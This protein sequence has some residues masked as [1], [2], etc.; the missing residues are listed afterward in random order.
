[1]VFAALFAAIIYGLQLFGYFDIALTEWP[2][3][4]FMQQ[5]I[6][7]GGS[8]TALAL[9]TLFAIHWYIRAKFAK[10]DANRIAK[11]DSQ[12]ANALRHNTR[13][14]RGMFPKEPRGWTKRSRRKL[15]NIV[16]ASKKAIQKLN[17][18]FANPSGKTETGVSTPKAVNEVVAPKTEQKTESNS[19]N[20]NTDDTIEPKTESTAKETG[21]TVIS[22]R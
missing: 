5:S 13:F 8:V 4:T 20:A 12:L 6:Y 11:T 7:Y 17:D 2:L 9:L 22:E 10:W 18:Q 15:S 1:M 3:V 19:L 14:W 21:K 16:N